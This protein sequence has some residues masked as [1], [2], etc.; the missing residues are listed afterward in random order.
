MIDAPFLKWLAIRRATPRRT[1]ARSPCSTSTVETSESCWQGPRCTF[2]DA[3]CPPICSNSY[4]KPPKV[5]CLRSMV[6]R[7]GYEAVGDFGEL[8]KNFCT[9]D[10]PMTRPLRLRVKGT[11]PLHAGTVR[12]QVATLHGKIGVN[13]CNAFRGPGRER[14]IAS[15]R[16][17]CISDFNAAYDRGDGTSHAAV[18]SRSAACSPRFRCKKEPGQPCPFAARVSP[19]ARHARP[20][21]RAGAWGLRPVRCSPSMV[22]QGSVGGTTPRFVAGESRN[23]DRRAS[24]KCLFRIRA[25]ASWPRRGRSRSAPG[26][27]R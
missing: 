12:N 3:P 17:D 27:C 11:L 13:R 8:R 24:I 14:G 10:A 22:L 1:W 21:I 6:L 19:S 7:R 20:G 25:T 26:V 2:H 4:A 15:H 5:T 23:R 9:R 16:C 18:C